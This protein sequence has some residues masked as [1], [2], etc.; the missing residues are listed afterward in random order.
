MADMDAANV[1]LEDANTR[2]EAAL[3][4]AQGEA[5]AAA[6]GLQAQLAQ[7]VLARAACMLHMHMHAHARMHMHGG[8]KV[9]VLGGGCMHCHL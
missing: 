6:A 8:C 3:E 7:Q 5:R 9:A 4:A 1:E 2:L